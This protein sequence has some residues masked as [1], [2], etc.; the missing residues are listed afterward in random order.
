[1]GEIKDAVVE[2]IMYPG[3]VHTLTNLEFTIEVIDDSDVN[4]LNECITSLR[5]S[6]DYQDT[7]VITLVPD[8]IIRRLLRTWRFNYLWDAGTDARL[9]DT[10]SRIRLS[11]TNVAGS[12][13]KV[14]LHDLVSIFA[15]PIESVVNK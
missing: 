8:D 10:Y 6:N 13:R 1:M 5:V 11:Y 3:I 9:R 15:L 2:V 12:N 4:K 14:I 7:G